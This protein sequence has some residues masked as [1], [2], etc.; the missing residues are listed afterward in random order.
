MEELFAKY[1]PRLK[2]FLRALEH[3]E[4]KI[5]TKQSQDISLSSLMRSL[6]ERGDFHFDLAARNGFDVDAVFYGYLDGANFGGNAGS[7]LPGE[8]LQ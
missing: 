4:N 3:E 5:G 7:H 8:E 1:E 6:R 2:W